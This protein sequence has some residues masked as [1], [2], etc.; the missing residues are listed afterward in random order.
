MNKKIITIGI[1]CGFLLVSGICYSCAFH[2]GK[3]D[4]ALSTSLT[5]KNSAKQQDAIVTGTAKKDITKAAGRDNVQNQTAENTVTQIP[6]SKTKVYVHICG[7]IARPGVYLVDSEAR[8][9]DVIKLSGGLNKNAAGDYIN[10]AQKI[11]DGEK[12][13]I[14]TK[15]EAEKL[16]ISDNT[17]S[18]QSGGS[19]D[20]SG[21]AQ[22]QD[23]PDK[24]NI[25][26]ASAEE[27]MNL[28]GIGQ[29]KAESIIDYRTDHGKFKKIDDL[30]N[31][32]GIKEG[33]FNQISSYI[34]VN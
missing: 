12:I 29:V 27:L 1:T 6:S 4:T 25:N 18:G 10:Q 31:I 19:D 16:T 30:M 5:G 2:S 17:M 28:P 34:I 22:A 7:A 24:V 21:S 33:L 26:T 11:T 3:S 23:N 32:P 15:K 14:P 9:F 8:I 13:Y 20:Q